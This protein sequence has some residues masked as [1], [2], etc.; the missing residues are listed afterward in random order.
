M[1]TYGKL[2]STNISITTARINGSL[3]VKLNASVYFE[4]KICF[5][6]AHIR[7]VYD[8]INHAGSFLTFKCLRYV[9]TFHSRLCTRG[10]GGPLGPIHFEYFPVRNLHHVCI[11]P[12]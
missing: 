4:N 2:I 5:V 11:H 10:G 9:L 1:F 8:K 7:L 12:K 6:S 3:L